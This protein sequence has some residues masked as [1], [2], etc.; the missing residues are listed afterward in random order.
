MGGSGNSD[1]RA[2]WV[3]PETPTIEPLTCTQWVDPETPTIEPLTCTQWVHPE[4]PTI[5]PLRFT[6]PDGSH[7]GT[8]PT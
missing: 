1:Y 5:E 6:S 8:P 2:H 3:H 4:T 7:A